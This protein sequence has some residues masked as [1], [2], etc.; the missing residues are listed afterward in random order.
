MAYFY[1]DTDGAGAD[2]L[3]GYCQYMVDQ[4]FQMFCHFRFIGAAPTDVY[5][6]ANTLWGVADNLESYSTDKRYIAMKALIDAGG[7]SKT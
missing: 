6:S 3:S 4:G 5:D 7:A 1:V 2:C